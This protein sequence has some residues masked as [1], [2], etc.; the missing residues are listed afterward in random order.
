MARARPLSVTF[1]RAFD[2]TP[3]P[4]EALETL[5]G[6][7]VDRILTSGQEATVLE[8]LPL[9]AELVRRAATGSLSCP[10]AASPHAMSIVSWPLPSHG[11]SISR[12]LNQRSA[13]CGFAGTT[14]SW[15]ANC[16]RRNIDRLVTSLETI[17]AVMT[18][19]S[20]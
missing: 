10:A 8:G 6:L 11:R 19:T 17:R 5:I 4:F 9:I 14:Y 1:H 2:M 3:D 15:A 7:G 13:A 18:R 12:R 16:A 20:G